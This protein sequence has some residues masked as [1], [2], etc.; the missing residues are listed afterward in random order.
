MS[1]TIESGASSAPSIDFGS[2]GQ[3]AAEMMTTA[4]SGESPNPPAP[5]ATPVTPSAP[6]TDPASQQAATQSTPQT[7]TPQASPQPGTIPVDLGNGQIEYATPE[8]I[9]EWRANGLRQAD[10][11]RKTQEVAE[12]RRQISQIEANLQQVLNNP[13]A[14]LSLAQQY[15]SQ[16]PQAA[17]AQQYDPNAPVTMAQLQQVTE[18]AKRQAQQEVQ[19]V[20]EVT[21]H[22]EQINQTLADAF[23]RHPVLKLDPTTEEVIRWKVAQ[24]NPQ[25]AESMKTALTTVADQM[26]QQYANFYQQQQQAATAQRAQLAQTG[27]MAPGGAA[28]QGLQQPS[29]QKADGSLDWNALAAAALTQVQG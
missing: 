9:R 17:Q 20:L 28:P 27:T 14:L 1:H 2:I 8:Q 21:R 5:S 13:Q 22:A 26:A 19:H 6:V 23:Q 15:Y 18:V 10:Y 29:Y 4:M 12:H 3:Q 11:T 16:N 24:M 7:G 25:D